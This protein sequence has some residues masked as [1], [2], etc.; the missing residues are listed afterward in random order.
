MRQGVVDNSKV[1]MRRLM[2]GLIAV[3]VCAA[4]PANAGSEAAE[5][6]TP[7]AK[8]LLWVEQHPATLSEGGFLEI[9]EEIFMF[10]ALRNHAESAEER[11]R[12]EAEMGSR[13]AKAA[14]YLQQRLE[15]GDYLLDPTA[16]MDY[17]WVAHML[18]SVGLPIGDYRA[19]I[20]TMRLFHPALMPQFASGQLVVALALGRLGYRPPVPI[21]QAIRECRLY[22]EPKDRQIAAALAVDPPS[23]DDAGATEAILYEVTHESL[24]LTDFGAHGPPRFVCDRRLDFTK[25]FGDAILWS[26]ARGKLDVMSELV[27]SSK[28]LGLPDGPPLREAL[29]T[30]ISKQTADGSFGV[31]KPERRNPYRHG[32]LTGVVALAL[33]PEQP[34]TCPRGEAGTTAGSPDR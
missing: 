12:Y 3:T 1:A 11:A 9:T 22:R 31:T 20:E 5:P 24:A 30:L 28:L 15:R 7:F 27:I 33:A 14:P 13:L 29:A 23:P 17:T 21:E 34:A 2:A 6:L 19:I 26:M 25:L 4:A 8:A 16:S 32:V 18:A 10:Y